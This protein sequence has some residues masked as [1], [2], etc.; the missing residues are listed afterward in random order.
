M[1]QFQ[2]IDARS[3]FPGFDEPQYKAVFGATLRHP[4]G[5]KALSNGLES[6]ST[7]IG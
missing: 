2:P 6:G 7:D 4:S 3:V 1:T 5:M